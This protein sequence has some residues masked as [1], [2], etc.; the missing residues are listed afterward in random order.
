MDKQSLTSKS[1]VP[2]KPTP[3][4]MSDEQYQRGMQLGI[5]TIN[6]IRAKQGLPKIPGGDVLYKRL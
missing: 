5:L 1:V 6:E 3:K 4:Q 2:P